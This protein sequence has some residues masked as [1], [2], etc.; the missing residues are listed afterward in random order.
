VLWTVDLPPLSSDVRSELTR[1]KSPAGESYSLVDVERDVGGPLL[2]YQTALFVLMDQFVTR[3]SVDS[4]RDGLHAALSATDSGTFQECSPKKEVGGTPETSAGLMPTEARGNY[5]PEPPYLRETKTYHS[6]PV[7][8][9]RDAG[10]YFVTLS[11]RPIF[12]FCCCRSYVKLLD[13]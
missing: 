5:L 2:R 13:Y 7:E 10:Y 11:I 8:S 4:L 3:S 9:I 6:P 1:L 12:I